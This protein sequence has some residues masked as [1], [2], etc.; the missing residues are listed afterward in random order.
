MTTQE[1]SEDCCSGDGIYTLFL[2]AQVQAHFRNRK[3][4]YQ[5]SVLTPIRIIFPGIQHNQ[6]KQ[7]QIVRGVVANPIRSCE[8]L[9]KPGGFFFSLQR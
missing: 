6:I 9:G 8:I 3:R 2:Q 1:T 7:F 5:I 4:E